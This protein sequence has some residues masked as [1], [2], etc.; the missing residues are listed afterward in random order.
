[1]RSIYSSAKFFLVQALGISNKEAIRLVL[2][3]KVL[4]NGQPARLD[5]EVLPLD[6]V[7]VSGKILKT[8]QEYV[9]YAYHKPRGVECTLN[10]NIPYN[11]ISEINVNEPV[12]PIG[13][14]DKDS[15][16]LLLLTNDGSI[17]NHIINSNSYQEKEYLVTVD[18]ELTKE[19][20]MKMAEGIVIMGQM[21]R[22]AKVRSIDTNT[23]NIIITQGLNRQ[24]RRMCYKLGYKVTVLKRIRVVNIHLDDLP[25]GMTR[26]IDRSMIMSGLQI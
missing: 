17:Y 18:K 23:F 16:G 1:M 24:I 4:V 6:E 12:F 10:Q 26:S 5:Q 20:I 25:V 11:L 21:T 15:E 9:Y 13:R 2:E 3:K 14:L 19:F 7:V 22:P 8:P